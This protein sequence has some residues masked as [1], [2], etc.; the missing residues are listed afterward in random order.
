MCRQAVTPIGMAVPV[1]L[2]LSH[3]IRALPEGK[4]W[5]GGGEVDLKMRVEVA[6]LATKWQSAG[7][8]LEFADVTE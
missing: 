4:V 5:L 7:R 1:P 6:E 2:L 3:K 8:P